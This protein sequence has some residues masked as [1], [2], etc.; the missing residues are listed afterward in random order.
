MQFHTYSFINL[1]LY[2]LIILSCT[3]IL[4]GCEKSSLVTYHELFIKVNGGGKVSITEGSNKYLCTEKCSYLFPKN[5]IV[6]LTAI[7]SNK[8]QFQKWSTSSSCYIDNS[9]H[10][11]VIDDLSVHA[12]FKPF[13]SYT[14]FSFS[15]DKARAHSVVSFFNLSSQDVTDWEW[16]FDSDGVIDSID[17]NPTYKYDKTGLYDVTLF[18]SNRTKK[19]KYTIKNA[20]AIFDD[21]THVYD[22][23]PGK[24]YGST[25]EVALHM[26]QA[27]DIVRIYPQ[28]NNLPYHEKMF[29]NGTGTK[30]KPI[31]VIG[32][33][34][35]FADTPIFDGQRAK[36]NPFYGEHYWN[37]NRQVVLIGQYNKP[38][39]NYIHLENIEVKNAIKNTPFFSHSGEAKY[40]GNAAGIRVG[41]AGN[42]T[43]S[44][45]IVHNNENGIFTSNTDSLTIKNSSVYNN[46]ITT[47]SSQEHNFYLGGGSG[48][49]A[50]VEFN[51]IGD[52]LND[53]QQF[54]SRVE[55]LYFRYNWVQGGK[56]SILD[57]VEDAQ[58]DRSDAYVYGNILIKQ[59]PT[60]NKRTI[61]FG[62][63]NGNATRQG[64]L[65]FYNNTVITRVEGSYLFQI[66][67]RKANVIAHKNIL[68][69]DENLGN[70]HSILYSYA[71]PG[72]LNSNIIGNNNALTKN[73][74]DNELLNNSQL[75]TNST[76]TNYQYNQ[77]SPKKEILSSS[78]NNIDD[79][80]TQLPPV[81]FQYSKH[82]QGMKRIDNGKNIGAFTNKNLL[83]KVPFN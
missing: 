17:E 71:F 78:S 53:G 79:P 66:N 51:H 32:I 3:F 30:E 7:N 61:L 58:N 29:I 2:K 5:S 68:Y 55:T 67:E 72:T 31:T 1:S 16:D 52:L 21:S 19:V 44:H 73:T 70:N 47:A 10:F 22:I 83:L 35:E 34:N 8:V 63:D 33:A 81:E 25:H 41:S 62:G 11:K 36:D 54:K 59:P 37:R 38:P 56:N 12:N 65:Y 4:T 14:D 43:I 20:I 24:E 60:N 40:I 80:T 28:M 74:K 26:L 42:V 39:A 75:V 15:T 69:Y 45:V 82:A 23:G 18:A 50:T 76:F 77:F 6:N 13:T 48:S 49:I 27:G 64:T 57:L 9:C 46:G